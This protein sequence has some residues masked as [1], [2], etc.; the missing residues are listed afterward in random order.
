MNP[1]HSNTILA[2]TL[3]CFA[4]SFGAQSRGQDKDSF[5]DFETFKTVRPESFVE[6]EDNRG[7]RGDLATQLFKFHDAYCQLSANG[8][9]LWVTRTG[10][11]QSNPAAVSI[12][13][14]SE[15]RKS[16]EI[17]HRFKLANPIRPTGQFL[18][19][20]GCYFV[21]LDEAGRCGNSPRDL[22]VYDLKQKSY[23]AQRIEDFLPAEVITGLQGPS[24]MGGAGLR[25]W[26]GLS[27]AANYFD[28][29]SKTLFP[30]HGRDARST[31]QIPYL[32]INLL[33]NKVAVLDPPAEGLDPSIPVE[34]EFAKAVQ[35]GFAMADGTR[36][37]PAG[38]DQPVDYLAVFR[39]KVVSQNIRPLRLAYRF[40][41]SS[42]KYLS[43]DWD[44]Y[45]KATKSE[46]TNLD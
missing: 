37:I 15:D 13:A 23:V 3:V 4:I 10:E 34:L 32:S 5:P 42:G 30:T 26:Q 46:F 38:H 33:S 36:K 40:D 12:W 14:F 11:N 43:I 24:Y 9:Y 22:V 35:C 1:L 2:V 39:P 31:S 28:S 19:P 17:K 44:Q 25:A 29:S 7:T 41:E 8:K 18:S 6:P 20:D 45:I 27:A 21:T 16:L